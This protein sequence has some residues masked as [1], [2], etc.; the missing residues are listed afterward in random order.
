[1]ANE[2][3]AYSHPGSGTVSTNSSA[4]LS[5]ETS[6]KIHRRKRRCSSEENTSRAKLLRH[7]EATYGS[8]QNPVQMPPLAS[9]DPNEPEPDSL[10]AA[11]R[12][13]RPDFL[14]PVVTASATSHRGNDVTSSSSV[15]AASTLPS[16]S[17]ASTSVVPLRSSR[18]KSSKVG[19]KAVSPTRK[20]AR[21][22]TKQA[23]KAEDI[24][25]R[26]V[27]GDNGT[28]SKGHRRSTVKTQESQRYKN[29]KSS[30]GNKS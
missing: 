1:M 11:M 21:Q 16:Q 18:S 13:H 24:T 15:H 10:L 3:D 26:S 2:K 5:K 17:A 27:A 25:V 29:T 20:S 6:P 28:A 9:D 14:G 19:A 23:K 12:R 8:P 4:T 7:L 22:A 30:R